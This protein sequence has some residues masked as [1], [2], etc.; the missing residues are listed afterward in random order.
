MTRTR[1]DWIRLAQDADDPLEARRCL[2]AA[3]AMSVS[4]SHWTDVLNA[5]WDA[6]VDDR[7]YLRTLADRALTG[8]AADGDVSGFLAVFRVRTRIL[9]DLAGAREALESA[10]TTLTR[11]A[12]RAGRWLRLAEGF[13]Q[14]DDA[15]GVERCLRTGHDTARRQGDLPGLCL[16]ATALAK[17][18]GAAAAGTVLVEA[19]T[20]M[21]A[22]ERPSDDVGSLAIA[23]RALGQPQEASRVLS[24]AL[25]SA[26]TVG[27]VLRVASACAAHQ[28]PGAVQSALERAG[29]L[30]TTAAHWLAIA[31]RTF[32]LHGDPDAVRAALKRATGLAGDEIVREQIAA[33]YR[34]WLGDAQAADLVGPIGLPPQQLRI[35]VRQPPAGW[36][37]SASALFEWLRARIIRDHLIRI[38]EADYGTDFDKH[39][40]ALEDIWTTGLLPRQLPWHPAEVLQLRRWQDGERTDH[41]ER[42][43]CCT[44]LAITPQDEGLAN[45]VPGLVDSC[46]VLGRD[47][48]QVPALAGQLLSWICQTDEL[49]DPAQDGGSHP[50]PDE[51]DPYALLGLLLLRGHADPPDTG[52]DLLARMILELPDRA[53]A[54]LADSLRADRCVRGPLWAEL[55]DT[56]LGPLRAGRPAVDHLVALLADARQAAASSA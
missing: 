1:Y 25:Q 28:D 5:A 21:A 10:M 51:V 15:A 14:L 41:L 2:D 35:P 36:Q 30:A 52:V 20:L 6:E 47:A 16:V 4:G 26:T 43:W 54:I 12:A 31:E 29:T 23:W 7:D 17:S 56:N 49:P 9:N 40:A 53:A 8:M 38:A 42:A 33:G 13:A 27:D 44:L 37:S 34:H 22:T 18:E 24:A 3:S 11:T 46:L 45:I 39:L 50:D 19:E 32:D 48:P 55:V